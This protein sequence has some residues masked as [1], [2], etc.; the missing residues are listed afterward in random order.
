MGERTA[1]GVTFRGGGFAPV[2][3]HAAAW[4]AF[5]LAVGLWQ[6]A[7]S[8]G[9][10]S[11]VF[12]PSPWSILSALYDLAISGAL[13]R[14]LSVSLLRIGA[15]WAIGTA[16]GI[17]LGFAMGV[18]SLARAVGMPFVSALF[19]IPK[20]A[21]LPLLILWLGIGE[22]SKVATIALGV[23]FPTAIATFSGI[24]GVPRGLIRMAQSFDLP[25]AAILA[26]IAWPGAL[27]SI[28]AGFRVSAATALLLV[29]AAEMIGAQEGIGAFI[30]TAGN[31]MQ[32]D[33]LMAGVVVLAVLGLVVGGLLS[34]LERR[35]LRWR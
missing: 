19:P 25:F 10:V 30:N 16:A 14:H 23:F 24:D 6:A 18:Y 20:I 26:K 21:L 13:W 15:G 31:L 22:P 28:I 3:R 33:Q 35:L 1:R 29:V 4:I 2:P 32:T 27:P 8:A 12:L 17:A 9:V 5:A 34:L 11:P 7:I